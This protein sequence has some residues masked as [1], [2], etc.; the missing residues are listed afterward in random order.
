MSISINWLPAMPS[1]FF[2]SSARNE[3]SRCCAGFQNN[4]EDA[5]ALPTSASL[6]RTGLA[7]LC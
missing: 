5:I 3:N 7:V 1:V 6:S 4:S 2:M